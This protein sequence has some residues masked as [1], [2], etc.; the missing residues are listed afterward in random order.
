M[1]LIQPRICTLRG[2]EL[3]MIRCA[4]EADAGALSE[5][6]YQGLLTSDH[7]VTE[8]EEF[9]LRGERCV[10]LVREALTN[11]SRLVLLA[12]DPAPKP[13]DAQQTVVSDGRIIGSVEFKDHNRRRLAH[14]GSLGIGVAQVWRGRGVGR[15]LIA[16]LLDWA[17]E[18]PT[19]EK[20]CLG[21]FA[22]NTRAR[23]LYRSMGFIEECRRVR[24]FKLGPG[25]YEDDI[26]MS[27]WVKPVSVP[28]KAASS[29]RPGGQQ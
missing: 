14:H 23:A 16:S 2:G 4:V 9:S 19:I 15:E 7:N 3:I 21:V 26:Q 28:P 1:S 17:R 27:L 5:F 8:P 13:G 29:P 10:E 11:P 18:H 24:E 6:Y 12:L 22:T 20:V 25:R